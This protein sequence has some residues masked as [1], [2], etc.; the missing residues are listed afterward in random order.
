VSDAVRP[1]WGIGEYWSLS[2][3]GD[4]SMELRCE[5]RTQRDSRRVVSIA[6]ATAIV[7]A[8]PTVCAAPAGI[9]NPLDLPL[10]GG[11]HLA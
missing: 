1:E 10:F 8:I 5:A 4:P 6:V 3:E 2:L 7:N 9:R 11:G